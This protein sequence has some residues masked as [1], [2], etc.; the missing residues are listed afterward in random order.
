MEKS[1]SKRLAGLLPRHGFLRRNRFRNRIRPGYVDEVRSHAERGKQSF[2]ER[3]KKEKVHSYQL[4]RSV[5]TQAAAPYARRFSA[6]CDLHAARLPDVCC[7]N[8]PSGSICNGTVRGR[9]ETGNPAAVRR[10]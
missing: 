4:R 9:F 1:L 6:M 8:N 3:D 5:V 2:R 7:V 10:A